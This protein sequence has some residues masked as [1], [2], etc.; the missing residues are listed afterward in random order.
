MLLAL[1]CDPQPKTEDRGSG[2]SGGSG[3][4]LPASEVSSCFLSLT[5]SNHFSDVVL[6]FYQLQGSLSEYLDGACSLLF[7]LLLVGHEVSSG[8]LY[9]MSQGWKNSN[10]FNYVCVSD[11]QMFF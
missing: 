3:A 5:I 11:Q 7:E 1:V 8:S 4:S 10:V 2:G 9:Q 6:C